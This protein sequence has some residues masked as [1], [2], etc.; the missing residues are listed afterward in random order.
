MNWH[1]RRL[2]CLRYVGSKMRIVPRIAE[3]LRSSKRDCLVDVFGGSGAVIMN[4]GFSKR[5]Y[6]DYSGELVN[7]FRVLADP[8]L[9]IQLFR[10]LKRLPMSRTLFNEYQCIRRGTTDPGPV[11]KAVALFYVSSFAFGGKLTNG[12]FAASTADRDKIKEISRYAGILRELSRVGD[13][14]KNTAIEQQDFAA[15]IDGYGWR[16]NTVLYCDPP[17][18]G[19]EGYYKGQFAK[20]D[21]Q[22]LADTLNACTAPAVVSYYPHPDIDA[23]YPADAGWHRIV[24][25]TTKNSMGRSDKKQHG[26]EWLLCRGTQCIDDLP[27]FSQNYDD[28]APIRNH[29]A[30]A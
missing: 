6:N 24:I 28:T 4:A 30:S 18:F 29:T 11:E 23:L 8:G 21:H 14:W 2:R 1:H 22:R 13:F 16:A 26:R 17:Y 10:T 27:L 19:T 20:K 15:C 25:E 3:H 5:I 9:R 12:G 7:F